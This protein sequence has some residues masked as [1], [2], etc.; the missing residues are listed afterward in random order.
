VAEPKITDRLALVV[1]GSVARVKMGIARTR[2]ASTAGLRK[3]IRSGPRI[4]EV[5]MTN[6]RKGAK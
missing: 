5:F 2:L 3:F 4:R 1:L 6:G